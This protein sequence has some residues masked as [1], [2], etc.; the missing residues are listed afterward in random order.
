[1]TAK[2]LSA[3]AIG[4][5]QF[6]PGSRTEGT[7]FDLSSHRRAREALDLALSIR[8]PGFNVFVLGENRSGRLTSTVAYLEQA[9]TALP[10][11][12]DWLY[13]NRF[14]RPWEP[15]ALRLPHGQGQV[16]RA[17]MELLLSQLQDAAATAFGGDGFQKRVQSEGAAARDRINARMRDI[18]DEARKVGLDVVQTQQGPMIVAVDANG[19]AVPPQAMTDGQR[20]AMDR[21]A[22]EIAEAIRGVSRQTAE[23]QAELHARAEEL[24][25][26][27]ADYALGPLIDDFVAA[28]G[29]HPGLMRW[30]IELR[31]DLIANYR[32]FLP[33][34]P[35]VERPREAEPAVRYAVN[36][37][38]DNRA[39]KHAPVVVEPNPN[40]ANLFG[41]IEYRQSQG[42]METDFS[43][44]R[45]GAIHRA[46]GG[47]LV[48][49]A[50]AVAA[51]PGVWPHL[52]AS[53][54]DGLARIEEPFRTGGPAVAGAP[55]PAPIPLDLK[56]VLVAAPHWYYTFFSADPEFQAHFKI[57]ADID[58]SMDATADNVATYAGLVRGMGA[59]A[60]MRCD[61]DAVAWLLGTASRWAADRTKLSSQFERIEDIVAEARVLA[62]RTGGSS[63]TRAL[64]VEANENRRRR[65]SRI[66][67]RVQEGIADGTVLISTSGTAIGQVNGLTVR[68]LGDHSFGTPSRV[69]ARASVGRR[70]VL[71]IER[72]VGLGGPIQQKGAL[73]LQG[74]LS[75]QFARDFP[76][77][78]DVSIT[79]E[80]S[81]G[82]VEGDSASLAE[83]VAILSDLS[84]I[85]VKQ[86]LAI[87]GSVNQK[88]EAQAIGGAHSK[89]EGFLRTCR[90]AGGLDGSQG[91]IIPAANE[92]NL[93]LSAEAE[94][95]V[96]TGQ[97]RLYSVATIE[98]AV[99]LLLGTPAGVRGPDGAFPA[100]SV[101]ARVSETLAVYD[102]ILRERE[103]MPR[104]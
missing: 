89:I 56:V 86:G 81:Y 39:V 60:E 31:N 21:H 4:L 27:T 73:V 92:R 96:R 91:A 53:L 6:D 32:L 43:L 57:K 5:P 94:E 102:R 70:G 45:A 40:F 87:T 69:T 17:R 54:R 50:D 75:G 25:R 18:Q 82:G 48:L 23:A 72:D 41:R 97:F 99:E 10:A 34:P 85:P 9:A 76:L 83:L 1:M 67:D 46:N 64:V 15:V 59:A 33:T 42:T 93:V 58:P 90:E 74:W 24:G 36:L 11:P 2:H 22:P 65:N 61:D 20:E 12:S 103:G 77:S 13:V 49:R 66:E 84:G 37:L 52:K 35:D 62:A 28:F 26:Q 71:N 63:V 88:G 38:V 104:P 55:T 47:V 8:D 101:F 44:I 100:D 80:Q 98:D 68:D 29:D 51:E 78:F 14:T 3:D 16:F 19:E 7:A 79:F 95:A 30:L